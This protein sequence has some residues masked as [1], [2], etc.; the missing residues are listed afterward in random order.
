MYKAKILGKLPVIKHFL[1][2]PILPY[3]GPPPSQTG[4]ERTRGGLAHE[5]WGDCCRLPV[6]SVF[7]AV[8]Q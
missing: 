1:F 3:E 2:R 7:A 6:L 5:R 8:Q 4:N